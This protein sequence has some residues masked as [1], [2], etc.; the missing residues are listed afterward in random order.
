[1]MLTWD[2]LEEEFCRL[3]KD[4]QTE[5][6]RGNTRCGKEVMGHEEARGSWDGLS[7]ET[8]YTIETRVETVWT[9]RESTTQA[10]FG[11][12]QLAFANTSAGWNL[13]DARGHAACA[14]EANAARGGGG[15][16]GRGSTGYDFVQGDQ[17]VLVILVTSFVTY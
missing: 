17:K 16:G 2:E 14:V 15:M 10:R 1:M 8:S 11:S 3:R 4:F 5:G 6:M 12:A 13:E 9:H 7:L